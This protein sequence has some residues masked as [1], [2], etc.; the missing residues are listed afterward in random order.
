MDAKYIFAKWLKDLDNQFRLQNQ[1]I[2]LLF[3]N[4][5][6]YFNPKLNS[7]NEEPVINDEYL[8]DNFSGNSNDDNFSDNGNDSEFDDIY[9]SDNFP[10]DDSL[11]EYDF[12]EY[13]NFSD[14]YGGPS[15]NYEN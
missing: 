15:D 2:L 1:K 9:S 12:S 4:A 6:S 7:S 11:P 3:D 8:E 14:N 5:T 13:N 10:N